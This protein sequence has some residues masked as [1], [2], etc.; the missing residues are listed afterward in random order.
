GLVVY[1]YTITLGQEVAVVWKR[2]FTAT[3]ML[4]LGIRWFMLLG[5]ILDATPPTYIWCESKF[6]PIVC[7][8]VFS[9]LRVYALWQGSPMKYV[10]LAAPLIL[11]VVPVGT[12]IPAFLIF[13]L[14]IVISMCAVL[15]FTRCSLIAADIIVL[16]L[17]WI[18]SFKQLIEMRR[19]NLGLSIST[20]L[21]RDGKR[22]SLSL[23]CAQCNSYNVI[24]GT[25]YFL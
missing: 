3:S 1:E 6:S 9:A 20:V 18:K 22:I 17:T 7:H 19:V 21:L 23:S 8:V 25:L 10:C 14:L 15:Y 13:T 2:R 24:L 4:L 11:G 5:S 12:N 16:V